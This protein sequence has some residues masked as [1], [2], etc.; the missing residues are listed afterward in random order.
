VNSLVHLGVRITRGPNDRDTKKRIKQR[1]SEDE[2]DLSRYKPLLKTILEDHV[3]GRLDATAFPYVKDPPVTLSPATSLRSNTPVTGSPGTQTASLRSQKPVWHKAASK[4]AAADSRQRVIVFVAGGMTYS[5]MREAYRLSKSLDKDIIIGST[6]N[7][8]PRVFIDDLKVLELQGVGSH[9]IPNGL[10]TIQGSGG[11]RPFQ[12]FYDE[13]YFTQDAP[14]TPPSTA[15]S[16]TSTPTSKASSKLARPTAPA[17][18]SSSSQGS[19][20]DK[21]KKKGLFRF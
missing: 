3:R 17:M 1:S 8:T 19:K 2:Y 9:A 20:D 6:H 16:A 21:K 14:P 10:R 12:D 13:H 7:L 15:P 5:E 11:P 4:G 18:D